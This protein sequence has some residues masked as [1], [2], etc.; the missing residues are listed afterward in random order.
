M[1]A[2]AETV[3]YGLLLSYGPD[4]PDFFRRAVGY[5][6]KI[7]KGQSQGICHR[8]AHAF[9]IS[10]QSQG[11]KQTWAHCCGRVGR[12]RRR[13]DRIRLDHNC[14]L[15]LSTRGSEPMTPPEPVIAVSEEI[16]FPK[17]YFAIKWT[18]IAS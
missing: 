2:P 3:P 5:V 1:S 15:P 10:H 7:L 8:T 4:F 12:S 17:L 16:R 9:R 13:V 18:I 14:L 6:E 11:R